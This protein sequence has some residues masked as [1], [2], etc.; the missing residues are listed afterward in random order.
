MVKIIRN[1]ELERSEIIER[2][3]DRLSVKHFE[4]CES[5]GLTET[6]ALELDEKEKEYLEVLDDEELRSEY[7]SHF[8]LSI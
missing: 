1:C 6:Q 8:L 4:M 5:E 2:I 7:N 3:L